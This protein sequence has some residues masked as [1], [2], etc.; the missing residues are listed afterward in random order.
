MTKNKI[1]GPGPRS[2]EKLRCWRKSI[3]WTQNRL[4]QTIGVSRETVTRWEIAER[5]IPPPVSL[6]LHFLERA[7]IE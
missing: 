7:E 5:P 3:G 6:L 1:T 4:A 2:A